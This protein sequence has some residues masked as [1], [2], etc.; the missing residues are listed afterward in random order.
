MDDM[1]RKRASLRG[2]GSE[3]LMGAR[4]DEQA[5]TVA[6]SEP[7]PAAGADEHERAPVLV[8]RSERGAADPVDESQDRGES[9]QELSPEWVDLLQE[10]ALSAS[11][12][13]LPALDGDAVSSPGLSLPPLATTPARPNR[14][15][16]EMADE[17]PVSRGSAMDLAAAP[18]TVEEPTPPA[19][20]SESYGSA[21]G[22]GAYVPA[23]KEKP[24]ATDIVMRAR[25]DGLLHQQAMVKASDEDLK[26]AQQSKLWDETLKLYDI[27]PDVLA[28]DENQERALQLLQ[29]A[30][31]ILL[32]QPRRYDLAKYRVGQVQALVSW[33]CNVNRWSNT[34]GWAIFMYE[35]A[36]IVVLVLGVFAAQLIAELVT[37]RAGGVLGTDGLARLWSTMMWGGLGGVIGALYSLYWHVA[38]VRD[39]DRQYIMWYVV[40]PVIGLLLGALVHL[41]IG[42]GFLIARGLNQPDQTAMASLLPYAVA[43]IVGFR[44]QSILEMIDRVIQ[45]ITPSPRPVSN[46]AEEAII[47]ELPDASE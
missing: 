37:S 23:P 32:A 3:I 29:E 42:A 14:S 41:V 11:G 15:V 38:K 35:V 12:N 30:Q 34:Y 21:Q 5:E 10:E 44:Q 27:V 24:E 2:R 17:E 1:A 9:G 31:D 45:V 28:G 36:W 43:C 13:E 16:E 6:E 7:Q 8:E 40:Q 25:L 18:A 4:R 39:F 33:R 20:Y 46:P 22:G 26:E 19:P 47:E